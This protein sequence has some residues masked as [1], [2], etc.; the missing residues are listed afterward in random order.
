MFPAP[1]S[2]RH[3]FN[4]T[5]LLAL[6]L[7]LTGQLATAA[8]AA[9]TDAVRAP[10]FT[11]SDARDWLN[12][13]P[14]TLADLRGK[15]VLLDVWTFGCWNCYRSF[16]WLKAVEKQFAAADFTILGVHSPE[17]D[18]ERDRAAVEAKVREFE[19]QHP[20]M[21]DNDFSYWKALDNRYWPAFY[22]ID[23]QGQIR[24]RFV[25]E[26]HAGDRNALAMEAV[27]TDLLAE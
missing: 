6:S 23:K 5:R 11:H 18:H 9:E 2:I 24:A 17:F 22:L 8:G 25:G 10:E 26:T 16:P 3:L 7:L 13:Q 1:V 12:S 15:V 20:V 14:L 21:L 27:I 19:L 4:M